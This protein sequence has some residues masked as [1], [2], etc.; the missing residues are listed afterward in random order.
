M[1]EGNGDRSLPDRGCYALDVARSDV[2]Y[3]KYTRAAR[4][5]KVRSSREWP[6]CPRQFVLRQVGSGLNEILLIQGE[7]TVEPLSRSDRAGQNENM[8]DT[9]ALRLSGATVAPT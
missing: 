7:T 9:S 6:F 2:A 5:E 4:F 1:N 3:R 8:P